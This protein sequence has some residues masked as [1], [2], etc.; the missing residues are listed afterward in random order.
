MDYFKLENDNGQII[1]VYRMNIDDVNQILITEKY[2]KWNDEWIDYPE[3]LEPFVGLTENYYISITEEEAFTFV[4]PT[5][6]R[7][8]LGKYISEKLKVM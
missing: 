3:L 2:D 7:Q 1:T 8:A 4:N 6:K 5:Q